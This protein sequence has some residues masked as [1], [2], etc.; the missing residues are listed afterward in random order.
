MNKRAESASA[1]SAEIKRRLKQQDR[2]H[3]DLRS[4]SSAGTASASDRTFSAAKALQIRKG[5][6][7]LDRKESEAFIDALGEKEDRYQESSRD[8]QSADRVARG[9]EETVEAAKAVEMRAQQR[10]EEALRAVEVAKAG[11]MR[12]EAAEL[13]TV[14]V[15]MKAAA[16]F[17]R[18]TSALD[19]QRDK[20][21]TALRKQEDKNLK[22]EDAQFKKEIVE[23]N[24]QAKRL[25]R[26][27]KQ[28]EDKAEA[29]SREQPTKLS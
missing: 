4:G 12:C 10:L 2:G 25:H 7:Y 29:L 8:K 16:E 5:F 24:N 18:S 28:A 17:E 11:V 26:E 1:K 21:R 23:L 9:A 13:D 3:A 20:T 19:Q 15:K 27:A 22:L 14:D 6:Q